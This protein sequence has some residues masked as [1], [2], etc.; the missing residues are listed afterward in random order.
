MRRV[1]GEGVTLEPQL[2]AHSAELYAV[3]KDPALYTYIDQKEPAS[4]A[5]LRERLAKLETRSSPDG[6]E[7]WLNWIVRNPAGELVG[8]VQATVD[9]AHSEAEIAYVLGRDYWRRGYAFAA[10]RTMIS[11]LQASYG[12]TH[13]TATL[14]PEN[15]ASLALLGKLGLGFEWEDSAAKEV[16]Y[17]LDLPPP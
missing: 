4:E 13:V 12:V 16:G 1:A 17:A 7:D 9:R 11:E 14:D 6:T 15:T 8:Y 10:C 3:I 5:A 2:A